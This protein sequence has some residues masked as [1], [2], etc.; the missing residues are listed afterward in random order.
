MGAQNQV[1]PG[2]AHHSN[3]ARCRQQRAAGQPYWLCR[4]VL[5]IH[6]SPLRLARDVRIAGL[7]CGDP[8]QM[9]RVKN[10]A[11]I[12][13]CLA[14]EKIFR[15]RTSRQNLQASVVSRYWFNWIGSVSCLLSWRWLVFPSIEATVFLTPKRG[16]IFNSL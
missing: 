4:K 11:F 3:K 16:V 1:I 13:F 5:L 7:F 15:C 14:S 10:K 6:V 12:S 9:L 2:N 8:S